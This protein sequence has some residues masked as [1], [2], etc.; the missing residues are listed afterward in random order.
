MI[1]GKKKNWILLPEYFIL[2][3]AG[4]IGCSQN[5]LLPFSQSAIHD[6]STFQ[7]ADGF[8]IELL[9]SEPVI[10]DPVDMMIDEYGR[11]YVVEMSG[12]PFNK[13]GIGQVI[14]VSD[15]NSDGRMDKR[16][17]F[18]DSLILPSGIM[19]WK[20]GAIVTDPPNVYYFEDT[21]NDGKADVKRLLLSGFDTTNLEANVNNP[22]YG[23]DNWIYLA[24]LPVGGKSMIH[25]ADD[26]LLVQIAESSSRFRPETQQLEALSGQ[27]Q[28]G[29]TFDAWGHHLMVNNSNH[30]FQNV[31]AS[32]YL[33]RN[34]D[35]IA[36]SAI[37]TLADHK[38]VFPITKNPEYQMLTNI[39]VF[40]SACGI[41]SYLGG[42]FPEK[43][44]DNVTFVCEPASNILHADYLVSNGATDKAEPLFEKKEFLASTD[45]YSRMVNTYIGPDGALYV[46]DFY[47]QIIEGP[48]FMAKEV[49]D[50][51]DL[52]NGTHKGRI[53]RISAKGSPSPTWTGGLALGTATSEEWVEKL[54][55]KNIWWRLN[56]QRLLVD[57]K[58]GQMVPALKKMAA[59]KQSSVG[60][61]HAL[62]TLEGMQQLS[63][64]IIISALQDPVAGIRENAIKLAELHL[65]ESKDICDALMNLQDDPDAKVR[66][67]LLLTLGYSNTPQAEKLRRQLLFNE[68]NNPW[69]QIA[70]LSASSSNAIELLNA[71]L[72][73]YNADSPAYASLVQRLGAIIGTSQPSRIVHQFI[74]KAFTGSALPSPWQA[75]LLEG[76][77]QGLKGRRALP[78]GIEKSRRVLIENCLDNP[79]VAVQRAAMDMLQAIGLKGETAIFPA[80]QK[81]LLAAKNT[82]GSDEQRALA[83]SF[84][85]LQNPKPYEGFL[86]SLMNPQEPLQVQFA[87][88]NTLK[89]I[90]G[91]EISTYF[92]SQ[93]NALSPGVRSAVVNVFL[94][95]D[96][97]IK[98]LL[99]AIESGAVNL[100]DI[101]WVQS[102]RLR[103]LGNLSLR[104]RSRELFSKRDDKLRE[105]VQSYQPALE[106]KGDVEEGKIIFQE[107]CAVCHQMGG[108]MGRFFGPDLGTV[109]AWAPADI[110]TNILDPN[111]TVAYGYDTW[112]IIMH[113]GEMVQ[114]IITNETPT[115]IMVSDANGKITNIAR[116][117]IQS[118]RALGISAMPAGWEEKISTQQMADLLT[119]LKQGE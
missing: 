66:L 62:W 118:L 53:Y 55:D 12:V 89:Q 101:N 115:A 1:N 26:S 98:L 114:G 69:M 37:E 103:S 2:F 64:E 107:N 71:V 93:W 77:A 18:A 68:I 40:T 94:M 82:R 109:H 42:A 86:K 34:P 117:D 104:M 27:T 6:L 119:F 7:I 46:V 108:K 30:I 15:T 54:A 87:A 75:P 47:R 41:V 85:A 79:A 16:T 5:K 38:N 59:N 76:L 90:P 112:E 105:V 35:M 113:N 29:Q 95:T 32:R 58:D 19:R 3:F 84:L 92:L 67:Q 28:F 110:M 56:A 65:N 100:A 22:E 96:E 14:L 102:V 36:P 50:T 99:D 49:L 43:Y 83:I 63:P 17:V 88:V 20:K 25:Y 74:Q 45:A 72:E 44:N 39:G 51:V 10:H 24:D 70:A 61:L 13:S 11:M 57:R 73:K 31:I 78:E 91:T 106:M 8:Q 9:A 4:L 81:A 21:D 111:R 23:L 33:R 52:Y 97:R 48:E 116:Q 80:M 60:R